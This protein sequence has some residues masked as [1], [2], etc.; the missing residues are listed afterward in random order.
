MKKYYNE[1][2]FC[3]LNETIKERYNKEKIIAEAEY[4]KINSFTEFIERKI[5]NGEFLY[6]NTG[7]TMIGK[8]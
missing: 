5:K 2:D 4:K 3:G 6:G 8:K 7:F 1:D